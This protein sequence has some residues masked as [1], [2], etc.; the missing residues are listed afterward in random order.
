MD[1]IKTGKFIAER[2]KEKGLTQSRLAEMLLISD[3]TISKWECGNGLPEV[4]LMLPLCEILEISVNELLCGEKLDTSE[5]KNK[6][7]ELLMDF[8]KEREENKKK[9]ILAV[10]ATVATLL[11]TLSLIMIAGLLEMETWLRGLL[12][13]IGLCT[14]VLG[15]IVACFLENAAGYFE[16]KHCKTRF[17]P[18][19]G[20]YLMGVHGLTWRRLKCPECGKVSNCRKRLSKK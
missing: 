2:R 19:M 8:M 15:L 7:E 17:V 9:I 11:P 1:Q 10:I 3:K 6:A 18:T 16:C 20:A 5:Y 4:S 13:G 12:I 14:L